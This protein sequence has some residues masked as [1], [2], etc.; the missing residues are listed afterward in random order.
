MDW[1]EIGREFK[2]CVDDKNQIKRIHDPSFIE[3]LLKNPNLKL[4]E[5]VIEGPDKKEDLANLLSKRDK[6]L[7]G[8]FKRKKDF[9]KLVKKAY[10]CLIEV[11]MIRRK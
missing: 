11:K 3:I 6:S 1:E 5:Y 4:L 10:I 8:V 7:L 2:K 9:L